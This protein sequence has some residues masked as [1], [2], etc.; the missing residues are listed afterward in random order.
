[1]VVGI[2]LRGGLE[3]SGIDEKPQSLKNKKE[4]EG[5]SLE[6]EW[7]RRMLDG[8]LSRLRGF[9]RTYQSD[10]ELSGLSN[11]EAIPIPADLVRARVWL[12]YR[13]EMLRRVRDR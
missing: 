12:E 9:F 3:V 1:M 4:D 6:L 10:L 2:G 11:G 8:L 5:F 13:R 7:E